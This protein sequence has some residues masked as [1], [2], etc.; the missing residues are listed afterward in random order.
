MQRLAAAQWLA[1]TGDNE[2]ARRLLRYQDA[3]IWPSWL[4]SFNDV[5]AAPTYLARARLEET[6][7]DA[8]RAAGYYRQFLRRYDQPMPAHAHLVKE[9]QEA[10]GRLGEGP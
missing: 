10:L 3:A 8:R 6:L 7:G 2:R 9:A 4:Y 5:L 1:E